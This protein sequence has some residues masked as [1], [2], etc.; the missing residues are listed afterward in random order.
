MVAGNSVKLFK[1]H[2]TSN[3]AGVAQFI[4]AGCPEQLNWPHDA[5]I[6][7]SGP[8]PADAK[9]SVHGFVKNY[10]APS[11]YAWL[12]AGRPGKS[13]PSGALIIKQMYKEAAGKVGAVS[14]WAVIVK[15]VDASY[16]GWLW[17]Y[18]DPKPAGVLLPLKEPDDAPLWGGQFF[19]PNC[20]AC[21]ASASTPES[22]F[23]SL[24]SISPPGSGPCAANAS[25]VRTKA[26]ACVRAVAT[27]CCPSRHSGTTA[28]TASAAASGRCRSRSRRCRAA[29]AGHRR[30]G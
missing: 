19:D 6:R 2:Y 22:T 14:G 28:S 23:A 17:G 21:H 11:V 16:D 18:V 15:Q 26:D 9:A 13:I 10:Y 4:W 7:M 29:A 3:M 24:Q 8:H 20:M 12:K 1:G 30:R 27:A 5:A 25:A